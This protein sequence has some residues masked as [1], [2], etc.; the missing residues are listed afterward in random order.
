[1]WARGDAE[2]RGRGDAGVAETV[3]RGD[4]WAAETQRLGAAEPRRLGRRGDM[5]GRMEIGLAA[6]P[7]PLRKASG[8]PG[9]PNKFPSEATPRRKFSPRATLCLRF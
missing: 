6:L 2:T 4:M 3:G 8:F 5:A 1:M 9:H 7:L